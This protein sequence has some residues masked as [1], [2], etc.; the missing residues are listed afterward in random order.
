MMTPEP[1]LAEACHEFHAATPPGRH[2]RRTGQPHGGQWEIYAFDTTEKMQISKRSR[3]WPAARP[4]AS[5]RC[6]LR[7]TPK[8]P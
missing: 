3:N 2:V 1:S 7:Y 5:A 4:S 8:G 6:Q